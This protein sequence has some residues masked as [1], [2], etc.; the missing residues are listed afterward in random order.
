MSVGLLLLIFASFVV[1]G[2]KT[3]QIKLW[4]IPDFGPPKA[5]H[6][7]PMVCIMYL[8]V[9]LV[10]LV[11]SVYYSTFSLPYIST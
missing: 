7:V 10:L 4:K 9:Y 3:G 2:S 5:I 1:A 8:A 6:V 11:S